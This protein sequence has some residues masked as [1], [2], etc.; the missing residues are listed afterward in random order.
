VVAEVVGVAVEV[1]HDGSVQEAVEHGGGDGGGDGPLGGDH[2]R[3]PQVALRDDLEQR[4]SASA[5]SV[6]SLT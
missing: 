6:H 2:D 3:G 4:G 1:D 5:G